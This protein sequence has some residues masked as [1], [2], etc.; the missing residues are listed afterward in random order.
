MQETVTILKQEYDSLKR[1]A[2]FADDVL[3]Q[4]EAGLKDAQAGRVLEARH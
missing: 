1:K 4:L 2:S 3:L